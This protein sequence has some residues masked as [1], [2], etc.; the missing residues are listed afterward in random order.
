MKIKKMICSACVTPQTL[1]NFINQKALSGTCSYCDKVGQVVENHDLFD[2]ILEAV[3]KNV[4]TETDL[5]HYELGL[6]YECEADHIKAQGI[7]IVLA[8]WLKLGDERYFDDLDAH[9]PDRY[10]KNDRGHERHYFSDDGNLEQNIYEGKWNLFIAGIRHSH[11]FFNPNAK[12][13]LDSVFSLLRADGGN[14]KPEVVHTIFMGQMLYRARTAQN[15]EAA[16][17][18]ENNP[19]AELGPP[20]KEKASNQ[21]MTPNGISA[22][23]CSLERS[24]CLSEIRSIT[25]DEVVSIAMTPTTQLKL[26]DLTRLDLVEPPKLTYFDDGYRDSLHLKA[27]LKSLVKKM[28]KPKGRNDELSYLSTQVVFEHLRLEFGAQVDGLIF[29]SVQTGEIGINVVLFPEASVISVKQYE[30]PNEMEVAFKDKPPMVFANEEKLAVVSGSLRFHRIKA[31][32]T[33]A[34]TYRKLPHLYMGDEVHNR[35]GFE[36]KPELDE[37]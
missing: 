6:I 35:L 18:I 32:K 15:Y 31:I 9:I 27:F 17:K 8:E 34:I 16:K 7:D 22:L 10:R 13:F 29:P 30:P 37:S 20:P 1:K 3:D 2:H 19:H 4:A 12:S 33:E 36:I 25:G 26:L 21:R 28:S 14:L 5:T 23:Y 24:T 11:R